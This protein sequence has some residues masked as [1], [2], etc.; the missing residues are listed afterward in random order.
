MILPIIVLFIIGA[1]FGSFLSVLIYRLHKEKKGIFFGKSECPYCHKNL[2]WYDLIPIVSYLMRLGKCG[3]CKKRISISYL[4]LELVCGLMFIS[5]FL[6]YPF[7]LFEIQGIVFFDVGILL[8]YIYFCLVGIALIGILFFD[9]KYLEIP[10]AFTLPTII[11]IFL[12]GLFLPE[13]GLYSILIGGA[14]AGLFFGAQVWISKEKWLGSGDIQVG[15]LMGLLL[16]WQLLILAVLISYVLGSF[17]SLFL[18]AFK[19]VTPKSQIPFA[20]FLV[21]GTFITLFF[22]EYILDL[23][24]N[25][26]F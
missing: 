23:Y 15:I 10:E 4:L 19:Q 22:G 7:L 21:T 17:I 6:I 11:L 14:L 9:A 18:M 5:F 3:Y 24:L 2:Q 25:T 26:I 1:A 13:P 8:K 16:G 12:V 20:P